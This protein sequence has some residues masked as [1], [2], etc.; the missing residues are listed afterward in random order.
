M[1]VPALVYLACNL[2]GE[3]RSGWDVPMAT[4]IAFALGVVALVGKRVPASLKI[5][6]LTL[7]TVDDIGAIVV[8][9]VFYSGGIEWTG[10]LAA[11]GLLAAIGGLR[12]LRVQ[13][14]PWCPCSPS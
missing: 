8:I 11:A 7:A 2:G 12:A 4:D 13:W 6:L 14:M 5:F 10:L 3:G 9:A 1:V